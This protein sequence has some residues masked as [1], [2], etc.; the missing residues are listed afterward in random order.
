MPIPPEPSDIMTGVEAAA[1]LHITRTTLY[2]LI[3][4]KQIPFRR[5]PG[6]QYQFRRATLDEWWER[7][8]GVSVDEA[9]GRPD[10]THDGT[11]FGDTGEKSLTSHHR[12]TRSSLEIID[13]IAAEASAQRKAERGERTIQKM[14]R[15]KR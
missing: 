9:L 15:I 14:S 6:G 7:C 4:R 12:N 1:Y 3:H 10:G 11:M 13:E 2:R 8:E 5:L